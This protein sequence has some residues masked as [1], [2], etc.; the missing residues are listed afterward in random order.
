MREGITT[1][2]KTQKFQFVGNW[3]ADL[4]T[5]LS[6]IPEFIEIFKVAEHW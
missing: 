4:A 5:P 2:L 3:D 6:T 1:L